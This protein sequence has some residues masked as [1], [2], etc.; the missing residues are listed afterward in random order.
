MSPLNYG[1]TPKMKPL[2]ANRTALVVALDVGTSKIACLIARLKPQPPRDV[3]PRRSHAIEVIG[4]SHTESF[5]MKAGNV[6]DLVEAEGALRHAVDLAERSARCQVESVVV[7][8]SA[9]RFA[10]ERLS[11]AIRM[12]GP[13]VSDR[14]IARVLAAGSRRSAH[15]GRFV[16]HSVPIGFSLDDAHGVRDPRGML[17]STFGIDMHVVTADAAP[18]RNLLLA[19]ES[20]HLMVEAMVAG[21]YAASLAT[22]ADDEADLGAAVVEMGAGTTTLAVFAEGRFIHAGGFAVGGRHVTLDIARGLGTSVH[23]AER[24]KT[25]YGSVLPGGA[26]ERDMITVPTVGGEDREAPRFVSRAELTRIVKPRAEEILEM[27]R[28]RLAVSPFAAEPRGRVVLTGGAC[29]LTGLSDLAARVLGRP[30]RIGRPLGLSGLPDVARGSA[31]AV[32]AGLLVYPQLAHLEHFKPRHTRQL[33]AGA[34]GYIAR[35]GRWLR[36][37]F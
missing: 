29:Q 24:I 1:L 15:E 26:D 21:S 25:L 11:A 17:A 27:V 33:K 16:L 3:L 8:I 31:F 2:A 35:V 23:D 9:G 28:D 12:S 20:C 22:L 14:D 18:A 6:I 10:S 32:A 7:S 4:F 13:A 34:G 36:E 37:S 19:V 30:V 5:G